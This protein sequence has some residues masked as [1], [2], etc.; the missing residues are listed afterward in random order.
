METVISVAV[1]AI[2]VAKIPQHGTNR[3]KTDCH[4]PFQ[5]PARIVRAEAHRDVDALR[6]GN[7]L[8]DGVV[9]LVGQHGQR[10]HDR[11]SGRILQAEYLD[12][13][14]L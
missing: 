5:R 9:G 13:G 7:T 4:R 12:A 2:A 6:S 1:L 3:G 8:I 10:A 11:E 14:R